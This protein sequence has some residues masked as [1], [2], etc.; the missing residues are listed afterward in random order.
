VQATY[1]FSY[2]AAADPPAGIQ[3]LDMGGSDPYYPYV[4]GLLT[5]HV[6]SGK[7]I[8]PARASS[9]SAAVIASCA[10]SSRR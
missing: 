4:A 5:R 8:P 6:I 7:E 3:F 9:T 1:K 10:S 2:N